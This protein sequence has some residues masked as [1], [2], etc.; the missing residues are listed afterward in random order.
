MES[1]DLSKYPSVPSK[2]PEFA[3]IEY[4]LQLSLGT[5]TAVIKN[6]WNITK[7]HLNQSFERNVM[8]KKLQVIYSFV[9][10]AE[11]DKNTNL[12]SIIK[13]GFE[14]PPDGRVFSTGLFKLSKSGASSYR[15]LLCKTAVGKSLCYPHLKDIDEDPVK[16]KMMKENFD[17]VYLKYDD[18][19]SNN[20][21]RY[22]YIV[23]EG[24]Q[25]HP[26]YLI[27]FIFDDSRESNSRVGPSYSGTQLRG[28]RVLQRG[29]PLLQE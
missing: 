4:M 12:E 7:P 14:I 29:N 23:Y 18:E 21:Y 22:E 16:P 19:E 6:V 24:S 3:K 8:K 28:S 2:G 13:E 20:I 5:S 9:D 27:D 25:V 17:S 10:T 15:V 11:L 26:E 1:N